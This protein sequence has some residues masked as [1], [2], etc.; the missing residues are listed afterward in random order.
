M[1]SFSF[2]IQGAKEL[3]NA[4]KSLGIELETKIARSAVRAGAVVIKDRAVELA[5]I[6]EEEGHSGTLKRSIQVVMRSKKV[7]DAVASVVT[8]AGKKY[9]TKGMN[10]WYAGMIEFGT[11]HRRATP[12]MRPAL[13]S[14]G[15]NA[16]K[17]MS[18][19]IQKRI[20]FFARKAAK[21]GN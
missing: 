18:E 8:R 9:N 17:R 10:A 11:K 3:D 1:S 19:V 4:L 14:Q 2:N 5:P 13:D 12:F 21:G 16:V 15:Q 7:G 6:S 20:A